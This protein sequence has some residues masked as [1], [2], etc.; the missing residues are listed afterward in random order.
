MLPPETGLDA[1][2]RYA[3]LSETLRSQHKQLSHIVALSDG[4]ADPVSVAGQELQEGIRKIL[5]HS[6]TVSSRHDGASSDSAIVVGT[7]SAFQKSGLSAAV[8]SLPALEEDGFWLDSGDGNGAHIVG[9][10]E[11]G[12][13]YGAFEY[14]SL[15]AQGKLASATVRKAYNPGASIRY[16]NQWDNLDENCPHGSIERGYGG[17]SIFFRDGFV[18]EDLS[19]VRQ[20]ARLL[21]SI[22]INGCIVNNVNS[23]H[24]LFNETNLEGLGRIADAMRPYGV[25]IGVSLF[26][27]TPRGLAGLPTS[28]PLDPAVVKFWEDLTAK[29]YKRIPDMLGYTIKANSEGQPGPLTYGRT[30]A[31]GANMFARALKPHGDGIVMYR[32][33][34]YNH[35][36]DEADLKNDRANAAVEYFAHLDGEFEDNVI[37]QIKFGP[38][39]FQIR[40]PPSP[41]FAHLRKTPV[42]CEFMV[43]QEYLGQ[44]SHYVYMAPE[45][46]TILGFDM[47]I[48]GKQSLVRDIAGGKVHGWKRSGYAAVTNVGDDSTWLGH[49]LS[50]SNLYAYGRLCWDA[51]EP[52]QDILLDWIRL[53]FSAEN[54]T[55]IDTIRDIGMESWPTYEAYSGNLGIQTLCDILYTHYGPS[56][57]SQD[58]NGWGQWTRADDKALGMDR[59]AATGTGNAAQYPP[60]VAARFENIETTPDDLLLWFH[61]VP[62]T[63]KLKSGKT[64]IQ[65]FYDAHYDGSQNAQTFPK[66]WASLK[67]LIDDARW[68]HVAFKLAYQAGHSLVWRDSVNNFY[69]AKCGIP[70]EKNRVGNYRWRIEAESMQLEGYEVVDV[71]PREAASGG[72]AV[73][74][75]SPTKATA[76]TRN[77][78]PTGKRDIAVNY[79]DHTGGHARYEILVDGK[80][81]GQW[82]GD[83]DTRLLHAFSEHVD[84]HSATRVYFRGVE[85]K[86]GAEIS[87]VGYPDGKDK[88]PLDYISLLPEGVVD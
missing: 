24:E 5:G 69:L 53:T 48:D 63:H 45:W 27:D 3:P 25:R 80:V 52:A 12:A 72:R 39:D 31:E 16:V 68:E 42:I 47:R 23:S 13:L 36:L 82:T 14:L 50:M 67:G 66:R 65:H 60:E 56:P 62:Y 21:A 38:I 55:V 86:E 28:D 58:G 6:L 88:A 44:Q 4:S 87:V 8:Q 30:L 71:T 54:S 73:V 46:E 20:Y 22:R 40:E 64:V 9:Q 51:T 49:H 79:Y 70:D 84:G 17:K 32:A 15:L 76:T 75:S 2:L 78:F 61:H 26:F 19:R 74:A 7:V 77:P 83:L 11:R 33:F 1:W 41:L 59:T 29:L 35:H 57:G 43:C 85:V 10:N 37:I 18:L 81:V 34:V